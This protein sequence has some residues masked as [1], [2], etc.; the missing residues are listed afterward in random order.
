MANQEF[1]VGPGIEITA[2]EQFR[3]LLNTAYDNGEKNGGS[4]DWNDVQLALDKAVEALGNGAQDFMDRAEVG[5]IEDGAGIFF[6]PGT[7]VTNVVMAAAKLVNAYR[8]PESVK[9]EDVDEAWHL[10]SAEPIPAP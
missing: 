10:L 5:E 6:M 9:W 7:D 3:N 4:M 2:L 1:F 8:F